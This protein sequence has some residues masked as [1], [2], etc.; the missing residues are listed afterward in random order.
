MSRL[1][2]EVRVSDL[3]GLLRAS[4]WLL[5]AAT[6]ALVLLDRVGSLGLTLAGTA[7]MM[8]GWYLVVCLV[9]V[10]AFDRVWK[11]PV[12]E[13][14]AH[15][16]AYP[17]AVAV[18]YRWHELGL[19]FHAGLREV[20]HWHQDQLGA[21]EAL[22]ARERPVFVLAGRAHQRELEARRFYVWGG[23]ARVVY[24]ANIPP[25]AARRGSPTAGPERSGAA[26]GADGSAPVAACARE[27]EP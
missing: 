18:T 7:G 1:P 26:A 24:G 23:D 9:F 6:L 13:L 15:V 10:P 22:L 16:R 11:R 25:R 8:A 17:G 19:N 27:A 3:V 4:L 2:R 12:R 21:L 20:C 5:A 14:A